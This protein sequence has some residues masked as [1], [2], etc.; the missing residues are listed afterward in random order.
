MDIELV[1]FDIAGTTVADNGNVNK[2][3]RDAF[4]AESIV[5]K[6]ADVD[7]LMGYRKIEAIGIILEQYAPEP[8]DQK[9]LIERIHE[10]FNNDMVSFYENDPEL[11][12]LSYAE[13]VFQILSH[14]GIKV[15]LNTGFTR[16]ITHA[17]L[18]RLGWDKNPF[19]SQVIC[20]D[21]VPEGRPHPF[22]IQAIMQQSGVIDPLQVAKVGDTQVD[23]SEGKNAGCGLVV[24]VTTGACTRE[25]LTEYGPD[26]IINSLRDLP[27]LIQNS[28]SRF[29]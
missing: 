5:V 9:E 11:K 25:Q 6:T 22:M 3:F 15:A 28:D 19:I 23:V 17:I 14:H 18:K 2:A 16:R 1:V 13:D 12:P 7:K 21:E 24:A 4:L 26:F 8:T 29:I 20:S 27:E 10:R